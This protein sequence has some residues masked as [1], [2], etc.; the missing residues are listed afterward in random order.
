M[1]RGEILGQV[2]WDP[3]DHIVEVVGYPSAEVTGI[4]ERILAMF[5]PVVGGLLDGVQANLNQQLVNVKRKLNI[6]DS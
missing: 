4:I 6:V 5:I 1:V 2:S 3:V